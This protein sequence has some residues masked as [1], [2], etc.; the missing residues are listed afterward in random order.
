MRFIFQEERL[1]RKSQGKPL[2]KSSSIPELEG[3]VEPFFH[4]ADIRD[5]RGIYAVCAA[6]V[7]GRR[8]KSVRAIG[9][10]SL[11]SVVTRSDGGCDL[12]PKIGSSSR[13]PSSP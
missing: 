10:L 4:G 1:A 13:R 6:H 2:D 11:E 8:A 3:E 12:S 5:T 9:R 7:I